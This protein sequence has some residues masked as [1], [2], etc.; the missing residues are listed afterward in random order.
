MTHLRALCARPAV[1][2]LG[3]WSAWMGVITWLIV[4]LHIAGRI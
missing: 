1:Q 3:L 2:E 4:L